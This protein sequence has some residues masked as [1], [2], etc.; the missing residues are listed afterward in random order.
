M[1]VLRIQIKRIFY[2]LVQCWKEFIKG[3]Q[4]KGKILVLI[5]SMRPFHIF[6]NSSA[7][8][9]GQKAMVKGVSLWAKLLLLAFISVLACF[10][11]EHSGGRLYRCVCSAF[12][13]SFQPSQCLFLTFWHRNQVIIQL[14]RQYS[15]FTSTT[16]GFLLH[17]P[18]DLLSA[19]YSVTSPS[20]HCPH[21]LWSVIAVIPS[22]LAAFSWSSCP[23]PQTWLIPPF[24]PFSACTPAALYG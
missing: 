10:S 19:V 15:K 9:T 24:Y 17:C 8:V 11:W 14:S 22:F 20:F 1:F 18:I 4:S 23:R 21:I 3:N 5:F 13:L 12:R 16:P 2:S 7:L 6:S